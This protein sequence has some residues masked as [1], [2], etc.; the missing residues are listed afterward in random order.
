VADRVRQDVIQRTGLSPH[1]VRISRYERHTWSDGCLGLAGPDEFCTQALVSGWH[2]HVSDGSR[3][4]RYRTDLSGQNIRLEEDFI[5][6]DDPI[7]DDPIAD[8]L[9]RA[10][11]E[12]ILRVAASDTGISASR[13]R[14]TESQPRL[15]DGCLGIDPGSGACAAIAIYGW[16]VVVSGSR[17]SWIYHTNR[18]GNEIRLN[19]TASVDSRTLLPRLL[20]EDELP[21]TLTQNIVFRS[22][23]QDGIGGS[24]NE[25][26]LLRDGRVV[27]I[28]ND[29]NSFTQIEIN[30]V[31]QRQISEFE[32]LLEDVRF[33]SLNQI[34]YAGTQRTNG[35]TVTLTGRSSTTR[36]ADITQDQL[37]SALQ[38]VLQAWDLIAI[39]G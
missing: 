23:Q 31:S 19:E 36:Y 5:V 38:E 4:W 6:D 1:L 20:G 12:Q 35:F 18:N 32:Q 10:L 8:E 33:G 9:P 22:I 25:I 2:V 3:C 13:L 34:D 24:V 7:A 27:Q 16:Q 17:G 26:R 37:P 30:R 14:I 28:I 29:R 21:A 15:W 39:T 11:E